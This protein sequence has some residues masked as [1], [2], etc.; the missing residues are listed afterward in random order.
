MKKTFIN[1]FLIIMILF[2][3]SSASAKEKYKVTLN[4]CV[5]GDTA[6]FNMGDDVIKTRFLAIDTP[7]STNKIEKYGKDASK[8]TCD[9]LTKAKKIE[10]EY[11]GNNTRK[12][13]YDRDLVWIWIDNELLQ[14]KLLEEGLAKVKYLYDDY[15]YTR[16]LKDAEEKA[17]SKK[18]N[19]WS[20]ESN[21]LSKYNYLKVGI[22]LLVLVLLF[23]FSKSSRNKIIKRG[24]QRLEKDLEDSID[25]YLNRKRK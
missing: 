6:Y 1:T 3:F 22:V 9:M 8:Y 10:I 23:V 15:E 14:K 24:K 7:E 16:I 18:I 17:K 11:D 4:K 13:K 25:K 20:E 2:S 19:I 5:D 21:E 12:D